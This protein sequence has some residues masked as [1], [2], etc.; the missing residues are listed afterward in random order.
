MMAAALGEIMMMIS[1][2]ELLLPHAGAIKQVHQLA[3][4]LKPQGSFVA[5]ALSSHTEA[6]LVSRKQQP[7]ASTPELLR[8]SRQLR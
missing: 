6:R 2:E 7:A 5:A 8:K 1:P 4:H 3:S